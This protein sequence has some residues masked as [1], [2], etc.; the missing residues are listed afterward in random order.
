M[1]KKRVNDYN[2]PAEIAD[3]DGCD[4]RSHRHWP[5][6]QSAVRHSE[7]WLFKGPPISV[8]GLIPA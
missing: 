8:E 7:I 4:A 6:E 2:D 1:P 5:L 3:K